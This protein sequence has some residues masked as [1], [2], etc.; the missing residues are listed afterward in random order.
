MC[1]MFIL[2][3]ILV[4]KKTQFIVVARIKIVLCNIELKD[5]F[6]PLYITLNWN[7]KI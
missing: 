1:S 3:E 6:S 4:K 2:I 5:H 7:L